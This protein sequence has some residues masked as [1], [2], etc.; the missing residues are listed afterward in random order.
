[1]PQAPPEEGSAVAAADE[2]APTANT[3]SCFSSS[4]PAQDGQEGVSPAR[5]RNSNFWPQARQAYSNKGMSAIV[6]QVA[7]R[8]P[9]VSRAGPLEAL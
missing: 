7:R 9:A 5:V 2:G 6:P 4:T 8:G 1:M 3:E